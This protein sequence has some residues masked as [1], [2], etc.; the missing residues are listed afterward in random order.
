MFME[1]LLEKNLIFLKLTGYHILIETVMWF[2]EP[3]NLDTTYLKFT[4]P[5]NK[6]FLMVNKLAI[7]AHL[8]IF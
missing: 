8:L 1:L 7:I 2:I 3:A 5:F 4:G 6:L